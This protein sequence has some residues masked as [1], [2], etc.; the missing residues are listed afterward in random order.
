MQQHVDLAKGQ[1]SHH[2]R[3]GLKRAR[4]RDFFKQIIR[5]GIPGFHMRGH[6]DQR[7]FVITPVF[8]KLAGDLHGIPFHAAQPGHV[9]VIDSGQHALQPVAK[10][11]EQG[12]HL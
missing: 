8:H 7:G 2:Q 10:L 5:Q 1:L 4:G 12:L 9:C 3:P 11:V 6:P